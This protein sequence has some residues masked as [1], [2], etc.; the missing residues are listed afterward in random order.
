MRYST[1][2]FKRLRLP[3]DV[4]KDCERVIRAEPACGEGKASGHL[5]MIVVGET[6]S[7]IVVVFVERTLRLDRIKARRGDTVFFTRSEWNIDVN[8]LD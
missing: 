2:K 5:G 7:D 6:V 1:E 8:P 4:L 3:E